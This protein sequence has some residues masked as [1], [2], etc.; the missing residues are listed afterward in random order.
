[1]TVLLPETT[2]DT[3]VAAEP[4]DRIWR[5]AARS[6]RIASGGGVLLFI[7]LCCVLT[8]PWTA[9]SGTADHPNPLFY[10]QQNADAPLKP[11][12]ARPFDRIF[13][14]DSLGHSLLG[15]CLFGGV[16]SLSIGLAA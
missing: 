15:R 3:P 9:R 5:R 12:A 1:M 4:P 7:L 14:T 10:D 16:I 13:G 8:L 11:P 6:G 2:H